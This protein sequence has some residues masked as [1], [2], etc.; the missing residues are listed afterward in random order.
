MNFFSN[1]QV[2][3]QQNDKL[4]EGWLQKESR[5]RKIWR[6]RWCVLTKDAFY[7]FENEKVYVNPT[8]SLDI[9]K[10][11]TVKTDDSRSGNYFVNSL[12]FYL[13]ENRNAR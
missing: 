10:I 12:F 3:I 5:F 2:N 8:E 1:T 7:T 6:D 11:K 13:L 4:K 9:K